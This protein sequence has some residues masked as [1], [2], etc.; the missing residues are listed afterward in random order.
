VTN[1]N[2]KKLSLTFPASIA[3]FP[4]LAALGGSG[5]WRAAVDNLR[6]IVEKRESQLFSAGILVIITIE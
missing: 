1:W 3:W 5:Y 6:L 2:P 4:S